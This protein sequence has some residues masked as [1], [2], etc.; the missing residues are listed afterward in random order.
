MSTLKSIAHITVA[1]ARKRGEIFPKPCATCRSSNTVAH[2]EDYRKPLYLIWLC[3]SCHALLHANRSLFVRYYFPR[4]CKRL[5]LKVMRNA[6]WYH[7]YDWRRKV[8]PLNPK[9]A[10]A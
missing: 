7:A 8:Q 10:H 4:Q 5:G 2:H 9:E 6:K 1:A 3:E